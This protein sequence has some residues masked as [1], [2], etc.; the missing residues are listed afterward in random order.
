MSELY[1][2]VSKTGRPGPRF[3]VILVVMEERGSQ[4]R[5]VWGHMQLLRT[6][7]REIKEADSLASFISFIVKKLRNAL[8]F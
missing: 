8:C 1:Q 6:C 5:L 2:A 3:W 4:W 7:D